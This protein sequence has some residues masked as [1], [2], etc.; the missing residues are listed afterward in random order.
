LVRDRDAGVTGDLR[1]LF[2]GQ[3]ARIWEPAAL[4]SDDGREAVA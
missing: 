1:S 2:G 3:M 4:Y